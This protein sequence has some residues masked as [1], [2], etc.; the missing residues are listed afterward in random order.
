MNNDVNV[1]AAKG[2]QTAADAYERGRPDYPQDAIDF[3]IAQLGLKTGAIVADVGAG[4]GKFTRRILKSRARVI[5]VEPVE[6]MRRKFSAIL[7]DS[8]IL[9][10]TAERLPFDDQVLDAI[11]VA[12]AFHWFDGDRALNEFH[13]VLKPGGMVG[14]IWNAR[15]ESAAWLKQLGSIIDRYEGT[16]PRYKSG[17]WKGAFSATTL[18]APLQHAVFSHA[19]EGDVNMVVDRVLSISY[20]ASLATNDRQMIARQVRELIEMHPDIQSSAHISVPYHT[21]VFVTTR[22]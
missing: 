21:D 5:G 4:T 13:R 16:A 3:L 11:V 10:G 7:P 20:I 22:L 14:L 19:Q 15:D 12:Q 17:K 18:F 8:E 6:G 1:Y 2:F 9:D